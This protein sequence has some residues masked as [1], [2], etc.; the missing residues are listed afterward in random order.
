MVYLKINYESKYRNS[1]EDDL[2]DNDIDEILVNQFLAESTKNDSTKLLEYLNNPDLFTPDH[3]YNRLI[4]SIRILEQASDEIIKDFSDLMN[5]LQQFEITMNSP[6]KLFGL[7]QPNRI[8]NIDLF[9]KWFND[10]STLFNQYL[11][12]SKDKTFVRFNLCPRIKNCPT[13][14]DDESCNIYP[15]LLRPDVDDDLI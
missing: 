15:Q 2:L 11:Y 1:N 13:N 8:I 12:V 3:N 9:E 6:R 14:N 5:S 4:D 7:T 10:N